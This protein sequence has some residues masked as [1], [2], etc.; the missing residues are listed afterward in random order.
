[1]DDR[2]AGW[3]VLLLASICSLAGI[4]FLAM[5]LWPVLLDAVSVSCQLLFSGDLT[6]LYAIG[7]TLIGACAIFGVVRLF[8]RPTAKRPPDAP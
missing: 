7:G 6:W 1:M 8:N 3:L 2:H 4:A 5:P